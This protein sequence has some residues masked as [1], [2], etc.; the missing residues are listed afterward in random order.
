[1]TV[2]SD[3]SVVSYVGDNVSTSFGTSPMV[4][5][6]AADIFVLIVTDATGV[7]VTLVNGTD[8]SITGGNGAVGTVNLAGGTIPHGVLLTGTTLILNRLVGLTQATDFVNGD[9]S[10]AEVLEK[11][12]DRLTMMAQQ[13]DPALT[14]ALK[15]PITELTDQRFLASDWIAR[16]SKVVG[17]DANKVLTVISLIG[18]GVL[19]VSAYIQTLLSAADAP[20]AKLTLNVVDSPNFTQNGDFE[21]WD[22]GTSAPPTGWVLQGAGATVAKNTTAGQFKYGLASAA[23]TRAGADAFLY[24]LIDTTPGFGSVAVWK[25]KTVTFGAWVRATV[26][27]RARVFCNDGVGVNYSSYHSGGGVLEF[28]TV[29]RTLDAASTFVQVGLSVDTG[30][31][32]AQFDGAV[33]VRGKYVADFIP[34]YSP[35]TSVGLTSLPNLTAPPVPINCSLVASVGG[36]ALTVAIKGRDGND[37][38]ATNPVFIPFRNATIATGD[39]SWLVL[40]AATSFVVSSGSTLGAVNNNAF[41]LWIVGFNDAGTFRLGVINCVAAASTQP[42][43][44]PLGQLPV[45]TSTAE[46]GVGTA[47]NAQT[48]YTGTAIGASKAYA[49]L[50]YSIWGSGLA[51]V[52][53]WSSTPTSTQLFSPNVPL[54][55]TVV[56]TVRTDTGAL[57]TGTTVMPYDDTPPLSGEG[58]QYM[59]LAITATSSAHLLEIESD[60][61]T[62]SSAATTASHALFQDAAATSVKATSNSGQTVT[63]IEQGFMQHLMLANTGASTTFKVRVGYNAGAT[64]TFNGVSSGRYFGGVMNSYMKILEIAT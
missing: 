56:Q 34:C 44:Y 10:D 11:A 48:F 52:G 62:S 26:A 32:T 14:T 55:G 28:I 16:A 37:P 9:Q 6:D 57:A 39:Y 41:K 2:L 30:D 63:L 53:T 22:A 36:S 25:N 58:D 31:T 51:T 61:H 15:A 8:Y 3:L 40:T 54:P 46:G 17:F 12:L 19:T 13:F 4:F 64:T 7:S 24:Q 33:F 29:T 43:I 45:V 35:T 60:L 49:I 23:L 27:S 42:T 47:D 59:S 18:T 5:F 20:S 50:G 1:M 38:S 21:Q